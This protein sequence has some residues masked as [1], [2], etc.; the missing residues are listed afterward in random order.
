MTDF[1]IEEIR[2][3]LEDISLKSKKNEAPSENNQF[4]SII[5]DAIDNVNN[6]QIEKKQV[7]QDYV[8]GKNTNLHETLVSLEKADISFKLMMQVRSKLVNAY[9]EIMNT[10]V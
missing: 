4:A 2:R 7:I 1:K 3:Q 5:K 6:D 8:S 10:Q 9:K